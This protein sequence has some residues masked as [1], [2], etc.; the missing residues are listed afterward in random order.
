MRD[1]TC[2]SCGMLFGR[3]ID[4]DVL[5][6]KNRDLYRV[7]NRGQGGEVSGPCRRCGTTVRWPEHMTIEK[8]E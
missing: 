5:A 4:E 6:I 2:P 8:G 1:I 3:V 7:F